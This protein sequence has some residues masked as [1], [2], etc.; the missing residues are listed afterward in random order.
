MI[1]NQ[2]GI[3]LKMIFNRIY[4][5]KANI[6]DVFSTHNQRYEEVF[7]R[8]IHVYL[9]IDVQVSGEERHT[10]QHRVIQTE[11]GRDF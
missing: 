2:I 8:L 5:F 3:C 6:Q 1:Y 9:R 4:C 10:D 7:H 11:T